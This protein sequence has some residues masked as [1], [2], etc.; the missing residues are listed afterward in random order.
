M[1][2]HWLKTRAAA[3]LGSQHEHIVTL[4]TLG[5]S[6]CVVAIHDLNKRWLQV[7]NDGLN[8]SGDLIALV[9]PHRARGVEAD[10]QAAQCVR[11]QRWQVQPRAD[12]PA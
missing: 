8:L 6:H 4:E 3:T 5:V 12:E 11:A 7:I 10:S 9:W 2:E 1:L